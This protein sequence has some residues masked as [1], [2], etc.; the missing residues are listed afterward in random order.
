MA[1]KRIHQ[2]RPDN[3]NAAVPD[4]N[5]DPILHGFN[6]L[7]GRN[8]LIRMR[9]RI[10]GVLLRPVVAPMAENEIGDGPYGRLPGRGVLVWIH[11]GNKVLDKTLPRRIVDIFPQDVAIAHRLP[12]TAPVAL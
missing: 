2:G 1:L 5:P 7:V 10:V 4:K 9:R 12:Q 6:L 11:G 3:A 8:A